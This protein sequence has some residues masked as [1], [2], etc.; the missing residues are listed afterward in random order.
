MKNIRNL[1]TF[2]LLESYLYPIPPIEFKEIKNRDAQNP[3][4]KNLEKAENLFTERRFPEAIETY[5]EVLAEKENDQSTIL[6]KVAQSYS[7]LNDAEQC[8]DFLED[9]LRF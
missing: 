5:K 3:V 2:L 4:E 1:I 8:V 6:K 9:Y 7:A